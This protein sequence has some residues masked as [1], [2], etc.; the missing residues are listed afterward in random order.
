[1][2]EIKVVLKAPSHILNN[3]I[4]YVTKFMGSASLIPM[5]SLANH[6]DYVE[7]DKSSKLAKNKY[8]END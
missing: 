4:S 3:F 6:V 1:M 5:N 7:Q 8:F 2:I